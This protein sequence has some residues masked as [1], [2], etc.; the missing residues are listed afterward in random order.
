MPNACAPQL[1]ELLE[2]ATVSA[3]HWTI[4]NAIQLELAT[5]VTTE[6]ANCLLL[7]PE[8]RAGEG[9]LGPHRQSYVP[10]ILAKC[11]VISE[12]VAIVKFRI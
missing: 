3:R 12:V 1:P 4:F 10:H 7:T 6:V 8:G 5:R 2:S 9:R 11:K